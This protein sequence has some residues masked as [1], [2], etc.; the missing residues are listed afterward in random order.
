VN[1]SSY[2]SKVRPAKVLMSETTRSSLPD[3]IE[4]I[5]YES[6]QLKGS[7]SKQPI[8]ELQITVLSED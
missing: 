2:L 6:L 8:Y 4:V 1:N 7:S 5:A 3:G